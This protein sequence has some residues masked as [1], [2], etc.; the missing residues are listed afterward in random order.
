MYIDALYA[1]NNVLY[2][3]EIY[4]QIAKQNNCKYIF[5]DSKRKPQAFEKLLGFQIYATTFV[6]EVN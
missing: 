2:W 5:C 4:E 3:K 6:K 1:P